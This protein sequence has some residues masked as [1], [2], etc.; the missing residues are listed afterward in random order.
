M[1]RVS[2][3]LAVTLEVEKNQT[4][5]PTRTKLLEGQHGPGELLWGH[6]TDFCQNTWNPLIAESRTEQE[7][8]SCVSCGP[9]LGGLVDVAGVLRALVFK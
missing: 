9:L 7:S 5:Q 8:K 6:I 4:N 1:S 2:C 3:H